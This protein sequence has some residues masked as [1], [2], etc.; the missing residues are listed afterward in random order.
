[1]PWLN[2][3]N[4]HKPVGAATAYLKAHIPP[5][6]NG[7]FAIRGNEIREFIPHLFWLIRGNAGLP[8]V[9]MAF[10]ESGTVLSFCQYG[11]LHAVFY[12]TDEKIQFL[13]FYKKRNFKE[14][15]QCKDPVDFNG[16]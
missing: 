3:E 2:G 15:A 9:M 10:E 7:G 5:S 11:V 6:F 4:D 1:M 13:E 8:E 12:D 14:V 16:V